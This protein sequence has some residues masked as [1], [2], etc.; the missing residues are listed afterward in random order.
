MGIDLTTIA[1]LTE[2]EA[3]AI[4]NAPTVREKYDESIRFLEQTYE[5]HAED[6]KR[7]VAYL[8]MRI[9]TA[10][11]SQHAAEQSCLRHHQMGQ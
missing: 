3:D 4:F 11:D 9:R 1:P 2:A 10:E 8:K 7:Y 5:Y 6:I